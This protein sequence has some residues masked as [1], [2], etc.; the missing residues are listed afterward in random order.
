MYE[1]NDTLQELRGLLI[2]RGFICTH[3]TQNNI[4]STSVTNELT[5][6]VGQSGTYFELRFGDT[7]SRNFVVFKQQYDCLTFLP[8]GVTILRF[9]EIL[10]I[11]C[12]LKYSNPVIKYSEF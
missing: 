6:L 11:L 9:P 12:R 3:I 8:N 7:K 10:R 4:F 1:S 5:A 2:L